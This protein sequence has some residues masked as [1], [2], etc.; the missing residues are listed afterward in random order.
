MAGFETT[1][2][3]RDPLRVTAP[4]CAFTG[5]LLFPGDPVVEGAGGARYCDEVARELASLDAP[6]EECLPLLEPWLG[7]SPAAPESAIDPISLEVVHGALTSIWMEMQL[8]MTRTAYSPVFF[9]G[10]DFTVGIF[11]P[12]LERVATREGFVAQMGAMRPAV[13]AA[14]TQFGWE[15]LEPGDVL[16]HNS[17]MLGTPHL[18]EF[19]M[20]RPVIRDGEPLAVLATIAHHADVGGKAAGGMPGDST[21]IHQEGVVIPPVKLYRAGE[22]DYEIWRILLSNTRTARSSYGDFMAMVGSL[23]I[24]ERR[25]DELLARYGRETL[26][27]TM[28]ELQ[29]YA[30]RR[31][32]A[33]IRE[34]PNGIYH[35]RIEA[36]DDGVRPGSYP[37][38]LA[39]AVLDEDVVLDFRGSAPQAAGPINC[40]YVVTVAGCANAIFNLVD[41]TIPHNEGAF[42][43]LH[44]IAPPGTI[45]NCDY[46]APLSAGNT[47]SHNLVAEVVIA[48]LRHAVPQAAAAPT[49]ATTGLITGGGH[50]PVLDEF[51]A[52]VIWEPTGYGARLEADGY[53]VTTWV[54]PQARLFP[55]EVVETAQPW[56]VHEYQLRRD[57]GGAG[58]TRG[59]VGVTRTYEVLAD[60]VSLNSISHYHRFPARGVDG[61]RDGAPMEIRLVTR[62][63]VEQL[64]TERSSAVSPTKFSSLA[65]H[66]GE[67]IVVRLPGGGGWGDPRERPRESVVRDLRD[68]LISPAVAVDVYGLDP[69]DAEQIVERHSWERVRAAVRAARPRGAQ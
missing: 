57:S 7:R 40:P 52:F 30:E 11:D 46:P 42:R 28:A 55:P 13:R 63:G 27:A 16:V 49:G 9:E 64:A 24:G 19:C 39:V 36:D 67:R 22:P 20:V 23:V 60:D 5:R 18:P 6:L 38:E 58:R 45:V 43:P 47:E 4:K 12:A 8:T 61:G 51:Y 53:S 31:M 33:C 68:E 35:A 59:G 3:A 54:A 62:D 37:I 15:G 56:R 69:D 14:I 41:H 25:I 65:V 1:T 21:D 10:E 50:H 34:I 17:S 48:A 2:L 26:V 66:A 29:R 44:L 32:R